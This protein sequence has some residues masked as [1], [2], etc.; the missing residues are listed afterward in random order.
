MV[1]LKRLADARARRRPR[2]TPSC[3]ASARRA[4]ARATRSTPRRPAGQVEALRNAYRAGRRRRRT[5]SSWSRR[6]APARR[7]ATRPR[8]TALTEVYRRVGPDGDVVRSRLGEVADRPHQG[9]G[10]RGRAHQG[11]AG[12]ASQGAAA[13]DQGERAARRAATGPDA[14]LRQ[15][16]E[17]AVA[18]VGRT[19]RGGPASARSASAAATS[20]ASSKKPTRDKAAIDWDGDVQIVALQRRHAAPSSTR[21]WRPGRPIWRGTN[22]AL[23]PPSSRPRVRPDAAC[24]LLLVVQRERTDL[25]KLLAGARGAAEQACATRRRG[26]VRRASS[27]AAAPPRASWPCCS[28][29]RARSIVGMLRDLACH[30][31]AGCTTRWPRRDRAYADDGRPR[32]SDLHLSARPPSRRK[33]ARPTRPPCAPPTSPS[34]PSARSASG[35]WRVLER[36]G[37]RADAV[38]GHSYGELTALC[39]AGRLD[40][41]GLACPVAAARPAHGRR[42]PAAATPAR[43]SPCR[44][45][46]KPI[47][48]VLRDEK[49]DLVLANKNAPQQTVLSGPTRGDRA[50]GDGVRR[51]GRCGTTRL[52]VAAAFHSPLVADA[53]E[54]L[55]RRAGQGADSARRR[56]RSTPTRPA[57]PYPDDAD[58]ARDLLGRPAG[59]A[60]RVRRG[61]RAPVSLPAC[62]PSSKSAPARRLTGLVGAILRRAASM[63]RWRWTPRPASAPASFDLACCLAWLAA[64]GHARRLDR[65]GRRRSAATAAGDGKPTLTVPMCGANY[66]KPKPQPSAT[67]DAGATGIARRAHPAVT[68]PARR[69]HA[70]ASRLAPTPNGSSSPTMT[71]SDPA[72]PPPPRRRPRRAGRRRCR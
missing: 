60:G 18:A 65:L 35:R 53:A 30:F 45:R 13:D 37:V 6:T 22:S 71:G 52:P 5:R 39:A 28:P 64:L 38:A 63:R 44:R 7:S 31:P 59:P 42:R 70:P 23:A 51:R 62:G 26:A 4:T 12:P 21:S 43:C 49:L 47:A 17:A 69:D 41:G 57:T 14:V 15:H 9:G 25:A 24:R 2:S 27:T 66:V 20:T 56:C 29:A 50:G 54:P 46:P 1:V 11:G 36:F 33:R 68:H 32:L 10:R 55:P 72:A 16:G 19:I 48:A 8:S 34:R 58:A 67:P 61:D 3:A 40:A